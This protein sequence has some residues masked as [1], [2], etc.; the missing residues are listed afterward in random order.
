MTWTSILESRKP[1]QHKLTEF[2]DFLS[3]V[4]VPQRG[5]T[6]SLPNLLTRLDQMPDYSIFRGY[7]IASTTSSAWPSAQVTWEQ[8]SL[9]CSCLFPSQQYNLATAIEAADAY[10]VF[11]PHN[12]AIESYIREKKITTLV[13]ISSNNPGN[14]FLEIEALNVFSRSTMYHFTLSSKLPWSVSSYL[15]ETQTDTLIPKSPPCRS[16]SCISFI[17]W[18]HT[19]RFIDTRMQSPQEPQNIFI[20]TPPP[21]PGFSPFLCS[22]LSA[23]GT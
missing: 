8:K 12:D 10:T 9:T 15:I 16:R 2:W 22:E 19:L 3:Q 7:I 6:G 21:L 1:Y 5:L 14:Y 17:P 20:A 23:Q 18:K 11:A 13:G 4:L